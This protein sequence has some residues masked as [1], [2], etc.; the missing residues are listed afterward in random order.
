MRV[1]KFRARHKINKTWWY[2]VKT[3][4]LGNDLEFS[5]FFKQIHDGI[6]DIQTLTEFTGLLDKNGKEIYEGDIVKFKII[7]GERKE[8]IVFEGGCFLHRNR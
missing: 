7:S 2:G 6:L 1:I 3:E 8:I 5:L 4:I